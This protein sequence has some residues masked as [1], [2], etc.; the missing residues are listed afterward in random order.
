LGA[1]EPTAGAATARTVCEGLKAQQT[2][3]CK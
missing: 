2:G 1:Y 3:T